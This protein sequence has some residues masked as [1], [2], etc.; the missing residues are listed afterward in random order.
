MLPAVLAVDGG[1]SKTDVA[2]VAQD[3]TLLAQVRGPGVPNRLSAETL[4]LLDELMSAVARKAGVAADGAAEGLAVARHTVACM[5]N[6][7]LPEEERR[8]AGML[9][10][11]GWS[12]SVDVANDT[13][14]LLR[15]GLDGRLPA[16]RRLDGAGPDGAGPDDGAWWGVAVTCGAGI[17]C[18]GIGPDGETT[19]F[20]AL[21][22][23]TG[24]WGGGHGLASEVMWWA[25]RAEDGRGPQTLLREA[26]AAH[27]GVA[28]VR[29]ALIGLHLG[30]ITHEG[31]HGLV[32]VLFEVSRR[33][34][35]VARDL[36]YRQADEVAVMAL[37]VIRRLGLTSAAVPVVLGGGVLT[38]RDPA[39]TER[40]AARLAAGAPGSIMR[41]VDIPPIAG[42]AL[43]GLDHVG[44]PP[45]A[46]AR[47]RAAYLG[48][49]S[50]SVPAAGP[51]QH[52]RQGQAP[53]LGAQ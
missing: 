19:G 17:N 51:V 25:A 1:N 28:A 45:S 13:V 46:H 6:V 50:T 53:A 15:A 35:Q 44:A 22:T 40:L 34:D 3:G 33:G 21:G 18:V 24:D 49:S 10:S 43:L 47:L 9:R 36:V 27:F 12:H 7:D 16:G 20:L 37:T 31:L 5:A 8:L 52:Q 2:L 29:D 42:A 4:V 26:V 14:A 23:L 41:I 38:A 30:S 48:Q 11:R 32:P 39:L